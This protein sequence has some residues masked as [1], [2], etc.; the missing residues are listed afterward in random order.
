M[1]KFLNLIKAM[2]FGTA[3]SAAVQVGVSTDTQPR[4]QIDAGGKHTWGPGGSTAG[5]TTLYRSA[6]DTLKTDDAFIA[7]G[8]LTIKSYE[9]DTAG[10]SSGTVL[11]FN[12]TKFAP[13]IP[14]GGAKMTISDTPPSSPSSGDMWYESDTGSTYIYYNSSWVEIGTSGG[15]GATTQTTTNLMTYTM[16]NMEF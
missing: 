6:A 15:G 10:A 2:G 4:L 14:T 16:M 8:G 9:V 7:A 12:G 13:A 3:A 1:S 11:S 5:D